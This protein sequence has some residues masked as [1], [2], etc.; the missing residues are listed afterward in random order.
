MNEGSN[1]VHYLLVGTKLD[2]TNESADL[3]EERKSEQ[4]A[5]A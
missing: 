4:W 2:K 5:D 1:V 3:I